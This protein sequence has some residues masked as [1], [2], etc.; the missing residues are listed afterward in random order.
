MVNIRGYRTLGNPKNITDVY[1]CNKYD[2]LKIL[3]GDWFPRSKYEERERWFPYSPD[4]RPVTIYHK[5]YYDIKQKKMVPGYSEKILH[6][7]IYFDTQGNRLPGNRINPPKRIGTFP[8]EIDDFNFYNG[9]NFIRAFCPLVIILSLVFSFIF[10]DGYIIWFLTIPGLLLM[11]YNGKR[12][13][14]KFLNKPLYDN[15]VVN[16]GCYGDDIDIP[17]KEE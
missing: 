11:N 6:P 7:P 1:V 16:M 10:K 9:G 8:N 4:D 17:Y 13:I 14:N 15:N 12:K 2:N 5:A 3:Y